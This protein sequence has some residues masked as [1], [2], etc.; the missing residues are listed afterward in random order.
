MKWFAQLRFYLLR[1]VVFMLFFSF[2]LIMVV[3]N[4]DRIEDMFDPLA[5]WKG[6]VQ[7]VNS[8]LYIGAYPNAQELGGLQKRYGIKRV[9]SLLDPRFPVS[10]ELV[11]YE[12]RNCQ[13]YGIEFVSL[14]QRD[15][16]RYSNMVP[17]ITE[18][19]DQK[20]LPT[21]IHHYFINRRIKQLSG[22]L[23][24]GE[25]QN[26]QKQDTGSLVREGLQDAEV[27]HEN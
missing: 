17:I 10:R 9:I 11:A 19:L 23:S 26:R 2:Y 3:V 27:R 21:Y 13:K 4:V 24:G 18:I 22:A 20:E 8:G 5:A 12:K 6:S 1:F 16:K 15:F 25:R 7:E 14:A